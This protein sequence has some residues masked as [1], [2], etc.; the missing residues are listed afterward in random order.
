[1]PAQRCRRALQR[2][3]RGG[4]LRASGEIGSDGLV[5]LTVVK[6][7]QSD[8][9]LKPPQKSAGAPSMEIP[10]KNLPRARRRGLAHAGLLHAR[11]SKTPKNK[12]TDTTVVI[13]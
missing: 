9:R 4:H 12:S 11:P 3:D 5:R 1:M 7:A 13:E 6:S 10:P 8:Y 2:F